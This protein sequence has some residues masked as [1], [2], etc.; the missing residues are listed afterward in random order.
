MNKGKETIELSVLDVYDR[1][2][3][4]G[5]IGLEQYGRLVFKH[6]HPFFKPCPDL[7]TI[8]EKR[9]DYTIEQARIEQFVQRAM[10]PRLFPGKNNVACDDRH[11]RSMP[12][13]NLLWEMDAEAKESK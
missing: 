10:K 13:E 5:V 11:V 9:A 1:Q 7:G 6:R 2:Y 8:D 12:Y 3:S 4:E